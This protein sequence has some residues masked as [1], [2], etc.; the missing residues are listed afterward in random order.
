[1]SSLRSNVG[2]RDGNRMAEIEAR[3]SQLESLLRQVPST[4][5][6]P[7]NPFTG[8]YVVE[9]GNSLAE[10][11]GVVG[12]KC[13]ATAPTECAEYSDLESLPTCIDG[14]GYARSLDGGGLHLILNTLPYSDGYML[15]RGW[16]VWAYQSLTLP[17]PG[18]DPVR[19]QRFLL[20]AG[21]L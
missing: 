18:T 16:R 11:T 9:G 1:M 14:V 10:F 4:F 17:I 21:V 20:P 2:Q 7:S 12:V 8:L 19:T 3:I 5:I 15:P 6:A 13:L